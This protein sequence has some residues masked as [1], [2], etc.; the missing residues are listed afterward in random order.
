MRCLR[1]DR[2]RMGIASTAPDPSPFGMVVE[3]FDPPW[4]RLD[5]WAAWW[6]APRRGRYKGRVEVVCDGGQK[7]KLRAREVKR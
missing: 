5:R 2:F 1:F 4:W 6:L 3:I 7:L